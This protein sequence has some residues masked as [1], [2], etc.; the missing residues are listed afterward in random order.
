MATNRGHKPGGG[1]ASGVNVS[2]PVRTGS[3]SRSARPA[4]VAQLG[5]SQG[6]HVTANKDT[7]YRGESLHNQRSFQPVP[8]GNSVALNVG[9]GG[10]GNGRTTMHCGSQSTHGPVAGNAPTKGRDI[11]RGFG[12]DYR[13]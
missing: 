9:K 2:P 5:Q 6:S 11:L 3:G 8:F 7:T 13:K 4:G 1:I 10:P 12:P